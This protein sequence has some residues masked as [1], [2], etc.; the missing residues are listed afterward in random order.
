MINANAK[1]KAQVRWL[2]HQVAFTLLTKSDLRGAVG[3]EVEKA[4]SKAL[5]GVPAA[6]LGPIQLTSKILE[7]LAL[8][9]IRCKDVATLEQAVSYTENLLAGEVLIAELDDTLTKNV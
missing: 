1:E 2:L 8:K 6:E 9:L 4:R 3:K 7:N 5:Q